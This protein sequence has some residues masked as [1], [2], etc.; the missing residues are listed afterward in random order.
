MNRNGEGLGMDWGQFGELQNSQD[1]PRVIGG[2]PLIVGV[3]MTEPRGWPNNAREARDQAAEN[4]NDAL[5]R[6][7]GLMGRT[8]V[9]ADTAR[10]LAIVYTRMSNAVRWLEKHGAQT[11]PREL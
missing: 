11:Q 6:L 1:G 3:K 9:S 8:D 5:V 2:V 4:I 7:S 10:E